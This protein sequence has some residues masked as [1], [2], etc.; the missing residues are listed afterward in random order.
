ML[1]QEIVNN[2]QEIESGNSSAKLHVVN[3][4][5]KNFYTPL[6]K[7]AKNANIQ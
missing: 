2:R 6:M 7:V 4:T 1:Q 5:H 3:I